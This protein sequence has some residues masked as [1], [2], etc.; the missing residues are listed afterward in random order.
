MNP[1]T[2]ALKKRVCIGEN[3][4]SYDDILLHT[5]ENQTVDFNPPEFNDGYR[6]LGYDPSVKKHDQN[7]QRSVSSVP[8][9]P[10]IDSELM[11]SKKQKR[12]LGLKSEK[13]GLKKQNHKL[14]SPA[15]KCDSDESDNENLRWR[16]HKR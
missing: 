12:I 10:A 8:G 3:I 13:R 6:G 7:T 15:V 16:S 9:K 1:Y 2:D 11:I 4:S 14:T 5:L